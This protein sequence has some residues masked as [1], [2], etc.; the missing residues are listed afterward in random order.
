ME[1]KE[2]TKEQIAKIGEIYSSKSI[3]WDKKETALSEYTGVSARAA[4]GWAAKLGFTKP[5]EPK[6]PQYDSAKRRK[7]DKKSKRYII[8]WAQNN[9]P[10]HE[11]FLRNLEAYAKEID[12]L[13]YVVAGRYKNPTSVFSDKQFDTWHSRTIPYLYANRENLHKNLV[14]IGDVKVIPTAIN[15]M[16]G[17]KGFSGSVSCIFGHPKSHEET[18]DVLE[19][20]PEKRM[21]T[22][23]SC[24][25]QNYTD[26]RAG[27]T[28]EFHHT[29][30]FVVVE[31]K[32]NKKVF[33]RCVTADDYGDFYDLCY[34]VEFN[35]ESKDKL[36][37]KNASKFNEK[38]I[39]GK[40]EVTTID[41][42][43]GIVLGDMHFGEHDQQVVDVTLNDLM[44]KLVP[45]TVVLHDVFDGT[46]ISHHDRKDPFAQ[47]FNEVDNKN[48]LQQEIDNMMV[49]LKPFA[50]YKTIIVR[51]NHDD[52]LDR[53]LRD[54][55]WRKEN[56]M[57]N[58][59]AYFKYASLVL[60]RK[61]TQGVIPYLINETYPNMITLGISDSYRIHEWE[62]GQHGHIGSG[63]SRGSINQYRQLNTKMII[64]HSHA[65]S[66]KDGVIQV[67]T[68]TKLRMGYNVGASKWAHAHAIIH[69][70]G[71]GQL[72]YID[73]GEYTTFH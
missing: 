40:S 50:K 67:G 62:V 70:N 53:W 60:G 65:P 3:S 31:I 36:T 2:L 18:L 13:I 52:F 11:F 17:M 69:P 58:A 49:G 47:Y 14:L 20:R 33:S 22:T 42:I 68:S 7:I 44:V 56:T 1:F 8:T 19:G 27:K 61:A 30:G 32:D 48:N 6:S 26:S 28:G 16:N 43:D 57:K 72:I 45:E 64:G 12:A 37:K 38:N 66:R 55:D 5:T 41:K 51:S 29:L 24:T 25:I 63:G 23:G 54:V 21:M 71:K 39:I 9:T 15:P 10:V 4:R 35:G 34:K 46:S 73:K 59:P